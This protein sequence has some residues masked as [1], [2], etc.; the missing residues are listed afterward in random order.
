MSAVIRNQQMRAAAFAY[1]NASPPE[2]EG[3]DMQEL[4]ERLCEG[5]PLWLADAVCEA[6][7]NNDLAF[8]IK[9]VE[10]HVPGWVRP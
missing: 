6:V 9:Q 3:M 4:Y 7:C 10:R 2:P 5:D 1:D 8:L